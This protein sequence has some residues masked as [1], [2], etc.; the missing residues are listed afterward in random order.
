MAVEAAALHRDRLR[1]HPDDYPPRIRELIEDGIQHSALDYRAAIEAREMVIYQVEETGWAV[2]LH[3]LVTPAAP[4]PAP[5]RSTT[6]DAVF[7]IPWTFT[8]HPTVSIP[9]GRTSDG[10]PWSMQ[11]IGKSMEGG[12]SSADRC[13]D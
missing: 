13:M 8:D 9:V 11:I 3:V 2:P 6:G 10:L 1:R 5:D 4:G 7:N 12:E